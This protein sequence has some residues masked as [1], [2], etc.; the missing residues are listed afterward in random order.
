[1]IDPPLR[2]FLLNYEFH[3]TRRG[4]AI[5]YRRWF[6]VHASEPYRKKLGRAKMQLPDAHLCGFSSCLKGR[7][8]CKW[9]HGENRCMT[10]RAIYERRKEHFLNEKG[11]EKEEENEGREKGQTSDEE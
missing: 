1:M 3:V 11:R 5:V 8:G 2:V 10:T 4:E 6:P 9:L 7:H